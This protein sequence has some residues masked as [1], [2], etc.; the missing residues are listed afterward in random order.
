MIMCFVDE[1]KVGMT[2]V[3][4]EMLKAWELD[5]QQPRLCPSKSRTRLVQRFFIVFLVI[6]VFGSKHKVCLYRK[7]EMLYK[8]PCSFPPILQPKSSKEPWRHNNA[9]NQ[10]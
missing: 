4:N 5:A 6:L 3:A 8:R 1:L 2:N 10:S 7:V 9:K